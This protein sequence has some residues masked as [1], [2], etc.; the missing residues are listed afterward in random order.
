MLVKRRQVTSSYFIT[1]HV[2]FIVH[3]IFLSFPIDLKVFV[4]SAGGKKKQ[5]NVDKPDED[6][7]AA[8]RYDALDDFDFM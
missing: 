4:V 3:V 2:A 1:F 5:L 6:F 7:V 8:D